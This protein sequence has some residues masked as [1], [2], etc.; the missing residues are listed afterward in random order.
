MAIGCAIH[1]ME[2]YDVDAGCISCMI[3][4]DKQR[5]MDD[6]IH[7]LERRDGA[8]NLRTCVFHVGTINP[9]YEKAL[10]HKFV[11]GETGSYAIVELG[12]GSIQIVSAINIQFTDRETANATQRN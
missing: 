2:D 4:H 5:D 12:D 8:P 9:V 11:S 6:R 7:N 10:F 1:G 3:E